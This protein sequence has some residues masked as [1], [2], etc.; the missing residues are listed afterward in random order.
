MRFK[1]KYQVDRYKK[2]TKTNYNYPHKPTEPIDYTFPFFKKIFLDNKIHY[3]FL[4]HSSIYLNINNKTLLIDP[5][6]V[7]KIV[8]FLNI[9]PRRFLGPIPSKDDFNEIDCILITHNHYDHLDINTLK[10]LDKQ[11][12]HYIVPLKVKDLLIKHHFNP[13][14][15]IELGLFE[16]IIIDDINITACPAHHTSRR[17]IFDLDKTLWCSYVIEVNNKRIFHSGDSAFSP[18]FY[19]INKKY[20]YFDLAFIECGQYGSLW[21]DMHMFPEESIKAC[22]I[23]NTKLAIPIHWGAYSL[24]FHSYIEPINRFKKN[25]KDINY[26]VPILYKIYDL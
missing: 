14:K 23:L 12:K 11:T 18:H 15:I 7:S 2:D 1:N 10:Q 24:A 20:D 21:H 5:I 16:N 3:S 25:A 17:G 6:F 26:L 22:K 9:G 19:D 13:N 4:G 8:P